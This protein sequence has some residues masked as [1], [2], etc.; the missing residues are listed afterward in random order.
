METDC[1]LVENKPQAALVV[2]TRTRVQDL[3]KV[4]GQVFGQI[5]AYVAQAGGALKGPAFTAYHNMDMQDLDVEIG[6]P[7][8]VPVPP[9]GRMVVTE[10]PGGKAAVAMHI[11]P[12]DTVERTYKRLEAFMKEQHVTPRGVA[13]EMYFDPPETPPEKIRTQIMF[14]LV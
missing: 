9:Q 1:R 8:A 14:P 6:F 7:V 11:G 2:R 13:Y 10:I 3:P 4:L 5:A 12:Y